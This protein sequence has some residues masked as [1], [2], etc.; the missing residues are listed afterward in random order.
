M[1]KLSPLCNFLKSV[2]LIYLGVLIFSTLLLVINNHACGLDA[3]NHILR[4]R[5]VTSP[6]TYEGMCLANKSTERYPV[7]DKELSDVVRRVNLDDPDSMGGA[8]EGTLWPLEEGTV[9]TP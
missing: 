7:Y 8:D 2:F 4:M 5:N 3:D 9:I 6:I 1:A